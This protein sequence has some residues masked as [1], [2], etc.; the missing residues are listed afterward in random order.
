MTEEVKLLIQL[1]ANG[2]VSKCF[3]VRDN[4]KTLF[5]TIHF[6]QASSSTEGELSLKRKLLPRLKEKKYI[7]S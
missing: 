4:S 2:I 7:K 6:L 3:A 5:R 1:N